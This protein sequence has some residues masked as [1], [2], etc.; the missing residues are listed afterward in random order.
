MSQVPITDEWN[1]PEMH[2]ADFFVVIAFNN[3]ALGERKLAQ[4]VEPMTFSG[5]F[6]R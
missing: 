3:E 5:T 6:R 1:V 4:L 2:F